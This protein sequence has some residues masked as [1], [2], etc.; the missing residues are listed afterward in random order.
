MYAQDPSGWF[1]E[2][3]NSSQYKESILDSPV[4]QP[5]ANSL[6]RAIHC[7]SVHL[8]PSSFSQHRRCHHFRSEIKNG[9]T[10]TSRLASRM[11]TNVATS[12]IQSAAWSFS[13]P[14]TDNFQLRHNPQ[15]QPP[16]LPLY[17]CLSFVRPTAWWS[18]H[19]IYTGFCNRHQKYDKFADHLEWLCMYG[20]CMALVSTCVHFLLVTEIHGAKKMTAICKTWL[21]EIPIH[22]LYY[23]G[24]SI[25]IRTTDTNFI[26]IKI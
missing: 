14:S 15:A 21:E 19:F 11:I 5:A 18:F 23:A 26:W 24:A 4:A 12:E 6:H 7:S 3:K 9:N 20:N 10:H 8:F 13:V 25:I 2:D 1:R 16:P 17:N 22:S